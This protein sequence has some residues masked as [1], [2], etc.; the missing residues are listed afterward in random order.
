[1]DVTVYPPNSDSTREAL[2]RLELEFNAH[3]SRW[4]VMASATPITPGTAFQ[5]AVDVLQQHPVPIDSAFALAAIARLLP[6]AFPEGGRALEFV[7]PVMLRALPH[8]IRA[9]ENPMRWPALKAAIG[10]LEKLIGV[11]FAD[12]GMGIGN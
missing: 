1:M 8:L 7:G 5:P 6:Y 10:N 4:L 9:A 11:K 2:N 12:L 3:F